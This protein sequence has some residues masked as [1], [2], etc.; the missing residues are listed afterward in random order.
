MGRIRIYSMYILYS[1][2]GFYDGFNRG[3]TTYVFPSL[4]HESVNYIYIFRLA[5]A[6][7]ILVSLLL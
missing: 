7:C 2:C 6:L 1:S 3:C 5:F 4:D